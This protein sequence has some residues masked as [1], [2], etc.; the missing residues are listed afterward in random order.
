MQF[1]LTMFGLGLTYRAVRPFG[2]DA[3][4]AVG[5]GFRLLQTALYPPLSVAAAAAS[6]VGQNTGARIGSRVRETL[7]WAIGA[8]AGI[9]LVEWSVLAAAPEHW[10]RLFTDA[11]GIVA[12]GA[13]Y[14]RINGGGNILIAFGIM[15]TFCSQAMGR[16]LPPLLAATARVA[17]YALLLAIWD[18]YFGLEAVTVFWCSVGGLVL[19]SGATMAI[20]LRLVRITRAW[21]PFAGPPRPAEAEA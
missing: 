5:V 20:L 1:L 3:S 18:R 13:S 21:Q 17:A 9:C 4:A 8:A 15:I 14:L 16:T 19:E 11:P 6:L 2:A 10:I 12:L 7:G